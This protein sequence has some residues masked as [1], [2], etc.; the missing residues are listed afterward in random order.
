MAVYTDI[1]KLALLE[2]AGDAKRQ[3]WAMGELIAP[4]MTRNFAEGQ[5]LF[6]VELQ[7]V[8]PNRGVEGQ[9]LTY[10]PISGNVRPQSSHLANHLISYQR[11]PTSHVHRPSSRFKNFNLS[12]LLSSNLCGNPLRFLDQLN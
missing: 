2:Y 10:T 4:P 5:R 8:W 9:R 1:V 12:S 11:R 3:C 7:R 6:L